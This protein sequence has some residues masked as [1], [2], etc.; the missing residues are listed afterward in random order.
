[1]SI[2]RYYHFLLLTDEVKR[3]LQ[4]DILQ[5]SAN[6]RQENLDYPKYFVTLPS[7]NIDILLNDSMKETLMGVFSR[8]S[9]KTLVFV[10]LSLLAIS[11]SSEDDDNDAAGATTVNGKYLVRINSSNLVYNA[12]GQLVSVKSKNAISSSADFGY[13]YEEKRIIITPYDMIY[14]LN[15]GRITECRYTVLTDMDKNALTIDAKNTYEYDRNGYLI[16]E[17]R[18]GY[19]YTEDDNPETNI[20]YEWR[21]GNIHKITSIG[22]F[23]DYV[24]ETTFSYTSFANTIPDVS[25]GF[26]GNYL[27]WQGYFGKRCKNLPA[28]ETV[29]KRSYGIPTDVIETIT[30]YYDY[31]FEDGLVTKITAKWSYDGYP[32]TQVHELEWY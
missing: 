12:Q 9:L 6:N 8:I 19:D 1:M 30:Y 7:R 25:Q 15:E 11:C 31:T 20:T 22:S 5:Y 32:S 18:H 21:D 24:E 16:K 26:I 4:F 28:S 23:D 29:T 14:Y 2:I 3:H 27:G 13:S 17:T 10:A